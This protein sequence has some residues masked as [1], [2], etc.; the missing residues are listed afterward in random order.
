[1]F[2]DWLAATWLLIGLVGSVLIRGALWLFSI[3][4]LTPLLGPI[5]LLLSP[6]VGDSAG[7]ALWTGDIIASFPLAIATFF[8]W[9]GLRAYRPWALRLSRGLAWFYVVANAATA[10]VCGVYMWDWGLLAVPFAVY[11]ASFA[12]AVMVLRRLAAYRALLA[13]QPYVVEAR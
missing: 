1:M 9:R 11:V 13:R 5:P 4:I 7:T 10:I 3:L 6:A 2:R 8:A 12:V